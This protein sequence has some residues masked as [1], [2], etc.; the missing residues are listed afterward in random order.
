[1]TP[2]KGNLVRVA[3]SADPLRKSALSRLMGALSG[4]QSLGYSSGGAGSGG[5]H[6]LVCHVGALWILFGFSG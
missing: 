1:M 4:G 2:C 3:E 5:H 6:E